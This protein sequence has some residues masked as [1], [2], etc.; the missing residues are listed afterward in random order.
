MGAARA[1][2]VSYDP[3]SGSGVLANSGRVVVGADTVR[4]QGR[5][6]GGGGGRRGFNIFL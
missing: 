5:G 6:G 2:S 4:I 1:A 3:F